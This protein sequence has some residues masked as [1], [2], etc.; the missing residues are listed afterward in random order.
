MLAMLHAGHSSTQLLPTE[1]QSE[2]DYSHFNNEKTEAQSG[3]V[4]LQVTKPSGQQ[5]WD[6]QTQDCESQQYFLKHL[7]VELTFAFLGLGF[8]GLIGHQRAN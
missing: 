8:K 1:D 5:N 4:Q 7:N 3:E 6:I 2:C